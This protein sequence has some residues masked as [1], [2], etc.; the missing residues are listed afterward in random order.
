MNQD[1]FKQ[2]LTDL[3]NLYNPSKVKDVSNIISNYAGNEYDAIK[4][5]LLKYNFKGHPS[6][7]ENANS[8]EYVH[9]V[10]SKYI[11]GN[12]VFSKQNIVTQTE[13]EELK[14]IAEKQKEQKLKEEELEK[15]KSV[16]QKT[17][18]EFIEKLRDE[19]KSVEKR[20]TEFE[21]K[22]NHV[23]KLHEDLSNFQNKITIESKQ[24][25]KIK[26]NIESLNFTDSDIQ[27][28]NQEVIDSLTKGSRIILKTSSGNICG[29]EVKDITYDL[30]SYE[31]EIV[32]EIILE[33]I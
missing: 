28:P 27:L 2:L 24:N 29:V 19:V 23:Q 6:Y 26:I 25:N 5:I 21:E 8:D 18:S 32:K 16:I 30:V 12:R 4:T 3:Y 22:Y 15:H 31:G 9:Y 7:N 13:Q 14:K 17:S 33:K 1:I 10:I 20:M 11:D